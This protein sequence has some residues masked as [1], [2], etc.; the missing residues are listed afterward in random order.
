LKFVSISICSA[1]F[2]SSPVGAGSKDGAVEG[3]AGLLP[4]PL[5]ALG[6]AAL[7][8]APGCDAEGWALDAAGSL[9]PVPPHAVSI[10][11]HIMIP[12]ISAR[13]LLLLFIYCLLFI[14]FTFS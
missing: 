12:R 10:A 1:N 7:A 5:L 14:K 4:P 2:T 13:I 9:P 8:L 3:C 6:G 11:V